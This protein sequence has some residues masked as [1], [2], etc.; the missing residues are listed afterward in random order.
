MG[1]VA[2]WVQL[3]RQIASTGTQRPCLEQEQEASWETWFVWLKELGGKPA[4]RGRTPGTVNI[5]RGLW[6]TKYYHLDS[7][8]FP[9]T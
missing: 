1:R 2:N 4:A 9:P 5:G 3:R 6:P 7:I 8:Y